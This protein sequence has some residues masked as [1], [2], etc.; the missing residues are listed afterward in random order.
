MRGLLSSTSEARWTS[1]HLC[2]NSKARLIFPHWKSVVKVVL[3]AKV[4]LG[5]SQLMSSHRGDRRTAAPRLGRFAPAAPER[6]PAESLSV[7]NA[8]SP[9]LS[10]MLVEAQWLSSHGQKAIEC[11]WGRTEVRRNLRSRAMIAGASHQDPM[12]WGGRHA[13]PL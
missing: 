13:R 12:T 2:A 5:S 3:E 8:V 9:Q 7:G 6:W 10:L 11:R 4:G 1:K